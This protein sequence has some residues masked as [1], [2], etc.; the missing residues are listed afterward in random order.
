ML[1]HGTNDKFGPANATLKQDPRFEVQGHLRYNVSPATA[2]SAGLGYFW[3]G[4]TK[5]NG[6]AQNDKLKSVY[7]R[8]TATHWLDQTTQLQAQ[9][10]QDI[11]VENGPKE[12]ARI[13]LRIGKI[14]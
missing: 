4:E 11:S 14:F 5:V 10:G 8:L 2:L 12:K 3:G 9:L 6:I 1:V 7:A 13:N